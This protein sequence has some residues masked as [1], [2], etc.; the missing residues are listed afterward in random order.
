M[1]RLGVFCGKY[2][3]GTRGEFPQ[4]WFK[5]AKLATASATAR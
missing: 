4:S 5:R 3:T 1:V 2:M